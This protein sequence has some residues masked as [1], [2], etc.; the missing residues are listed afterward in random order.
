[1]VGKNCLE[2][3]RYSIKDKF[4][5]IIEIRGQ[6]WKHFSTFVSWKNIFYYFWNTDTY[7]TNNVTNFKNGCKNS[8]NIKSY[9]QDFTNFKSRE[10][11]FYTF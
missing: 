11:I 2:L 7:V 8:S 4:S 5:L 6:R 3:L 1:M 9:T 10:A